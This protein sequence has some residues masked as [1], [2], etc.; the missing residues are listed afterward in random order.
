M[1]QLSLL[2][3]YARLSVVTGVNVQ[4]GQPVVIRTPVTA[5]DFIPILVE[6][7]YQAGAKK[8]TVEWSDEV[9]TKHIL[10]YTAI[11]V[12]EDIPSWQI[13]KAKHQIAEG[14]CFISV[15]SPVPGANAGVDATKM[16]RHMVATQKWAGIIRNV[17]MANGTQWNLIAV[18]NPAWAEKVFPKLKGEV[19]VEALWDAILKASRVELNQDAVKNWAAHNAILAKHNKILNDFNFKSLHFKNKLGTDLVVELVPNHIWCGGAEPD[20]KGVVFNPNIP[21]EEN[22][23]MPYKWGTRGKVVATKPLNNQGRIIDGFWLEFENGK[24][25]RYG[26]EKEEDALKGILETDEGSRYI[27]EIALIS[28]QS[29]ISD[30]GILYLLT[31]F[32]ENASCHM[33]LGRAY[34]MNIKGGLKATIPQLVEQGY[35]NSVNHVDFMFGSA[36]MEITGLTHDGKQVSVFKKGNFVI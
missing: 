3:E 5:R 7:A 25:V 33:A 2:K 31:L 9:S 32:D 35:N 11:E 8:V 17:T 4:P 24:V 21:T 12:L 28:H 1:P 14:S 10:N 6:A 36:D 16:Q 20:A 18:P 15:L 26:A 19:A 34:P 23:T 13:E 29:P 27:G 22:F 30:T